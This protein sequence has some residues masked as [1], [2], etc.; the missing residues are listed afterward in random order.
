MSGA[1]LSH[2]SPCIDWRMYAC[3]IAGGQG[4][5]I[6]QMAQVCMCVCKGLKSHF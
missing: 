5:G 4:P 1:K 3:V 2:C 6:F